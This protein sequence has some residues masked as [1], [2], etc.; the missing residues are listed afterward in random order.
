MGV[1]GEF[2]PFDGIG[3]ASAFDSADVDGLVPRDE[4]V[5]G[6]PVHDRTVQQ[7]NLCEYQKNMQKFVSIV[8]HRSTMVNV[9]SSSLLKIMNT[10]ESQSG[11]W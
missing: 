11:R 10:L 5:A 9:S 4:H 1:H 8:T 7:P 6:V 3:C 2:R